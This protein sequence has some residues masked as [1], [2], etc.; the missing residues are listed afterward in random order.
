MDYIGYKCQVCD[1]EFVKGDDIVVCPECGTP[2]HRECYNSLGHCVNSDKHSLNYDYLADIEK[3][4]E[5]STTEEDSELITCKVCGAKNP[6]DAFFCSRC[7]ESFQKTT[8]DDNT[9]NQADANTNNTEQPQ[10]PFTSMPGA[11][12]IIMFD[13]LAGVKPETDLGDGVTVAETAKFV[14]QNTPYFATV[15]N[16]IKTYDKSRFNFCAAIFGGGYLLYRKMYKIGTIITVIE[17]L[18]MIAS[19]YFAHFISTDPAF[20]Q[21]ATAFSQQDFVLYL[22][23]LTALSSLETFVYFSYSILGFVSLGISIAVGFLAN[24]MYFKHCKK[25][26]VKIKKSVEK[27]EDVN[28]ALKLK[29]GVNMGLALSLWVSYIAIT[30]LPRF[31]Y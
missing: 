11:P 6:S 3:Q 5:E 30:Y 26:I 8:A 19:T 18:I 4:K 15:F 22:E 24:R 16:N 9:N 10:S 17:A 13:P 27:P 2:H 20:S 21:I 1:N 31:F 14:R 29:G 23:K 7:G 12:N 28:T 25:E